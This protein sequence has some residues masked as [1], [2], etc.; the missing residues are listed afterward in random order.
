MKVSV[1]RAKELET[2]KLIDDQCIEMPFV[3]VDD[4]N[5]SNWELDGPDVM[6]S[7]DTERNAKLE[8]HLASL[9]FW[10]SPDRQTT[11][12]EYV[13]RNAERIAYHSMTIATIILENLEASGVKLEIK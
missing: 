3:I 2:D 7:D 6:W 1:D 11:E 8:Y 5:Y 4:Q 10:T 13:I 9:Q 12:I